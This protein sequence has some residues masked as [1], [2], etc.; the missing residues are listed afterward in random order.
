[1]SSRSALEKTIENRLDSLRKK[2]DEEVRPTPAEIRDLQADLPL[3]ESAAERT[4]MR[5]VRSA[6]PKEEKRRKAE[7]SALNGIRRLLRS[8]PE[9]DPKIEALVK[10]LC[11]VFA[12]NATDKVIVFT[13]YLDTL[14]AI[15]EVLENSKDFR[16]QT[17]V[18]RGGLSG[19]QRARVQKKF[20]EAETR[21]LLATDAASEG[22]NLQRCC[23]RVTDFATT[24]DIFSG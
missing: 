24:R 18:L 21:L 14:N 12:Q 7:V 6:I 23:H 13:E 10:E 19:R 5:V 1:M 3:G 2:A 8:L 17:V 16:D 15:R 4:A 22:L 20:E 11:A 9:Q